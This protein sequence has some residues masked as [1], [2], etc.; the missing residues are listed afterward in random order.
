MASDNNDNNICRAQ[1]TA[2]SARGWMVCAE[3]F[4]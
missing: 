3:R 1:R 2:A 4:I